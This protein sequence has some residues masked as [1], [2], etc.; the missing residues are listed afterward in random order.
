MSKLHHVD[1]PLIRGG[2]RTNLSAGY[3]REDKHAFR[4]VQLQCT[5]AR[6][7]SSLTGAEWVS[8][9]LSG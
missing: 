4:G 9:R 6:L 3:S 5:A 8:R 7:Q 1:R 2:P